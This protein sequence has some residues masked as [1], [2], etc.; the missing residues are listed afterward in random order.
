MNNLVL[1]FRT[2]AAAGQNHQLVLKCRRRILGFSVA[3]IEFSV[4]FRFDSV[5]FWMMFPVKTK[6]LF[7]KQKPYQR[8]L[9]NAYET[10]KPVRRRR[11]SPLNGPKRF[12]QAELKEG[13]ASGHE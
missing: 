2:A 1:E 5:E 6:K 8:F 10:L 7:K 12:F 13:P 11:A 4:V 9:Q 3:F